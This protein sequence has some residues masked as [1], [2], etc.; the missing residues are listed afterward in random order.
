MIESEEDIIV[1]YDTDREEIRHFL[2]WYWVNHPEYPIDEHDT[3]WEDFRHIIS[4]D[5]NLFQAFRT[6][7][8]LEVMEDSVTL[9]SKTKF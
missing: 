1:A 5:P 7:V 6:L 8:R 3:Y 9:R 2:R 4:L